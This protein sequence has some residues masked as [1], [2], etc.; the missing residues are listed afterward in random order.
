M[1]QKQARLNRCGCCDTIRTII[2]ELEEN[3]PMTDQKSNQLSRRDTIKVLAAVVGAGALANLPG[4]WTKPGL[5]FGVLP[6]HAQTSQIIHTLVA[7]AD[8][9]IDNNVEQPPIT[10]NST[11]QITPPSQGIMMQYSILLDE[12]QGAIRPMGIDSPADMSGSL[13]T[14]STGLVTLPITYSNL[15]FNSTITVTWTFANSSDGT[16]V[17]QQVFSTPNFD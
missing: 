12:P 17:D 10:I 3:P 15:W 8:A 9:Q 13:P 14:D 1:Y 16:G 2:H 6:A 7:G 11:V 4:K 5:D